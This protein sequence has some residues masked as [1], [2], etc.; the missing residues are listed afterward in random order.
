MPVVPASLLR[1]IHLHC[2]VCDAH[3]HVAM[4]VG[5]IDVTRFIAE[6]GNAWINAHLDPHMFAV[7][8]QLPNGGPVVTRPVAN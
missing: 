5:E 7:D 1:G 6:P 4:P 8:F 2:H 3:A